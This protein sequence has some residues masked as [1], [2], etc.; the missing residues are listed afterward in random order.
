MN[1]GPNSKKHPY[2]LKIAL[3]AQCLIQG[4]LFYSVFADMA[5]GQY[6]RNVP[7]AERIIKDL[8]IDGCGWS[9]ETYIISWDCFESYLKE[10]QNPILYHTIYTIISHW[11]WYVSSLGKFINYAEKQN[12]PEKQTNKDLL[13]LSHRPFTKQIEIIKNETGILLNVDNDTLDLVEEMH[14]VRNLGMHNEWEIDDIYLKYTKTKN[15]KLGEKRIF[16]FAEM[17]KWHFAFVQLIG[18]LSSEIAIC[19]AQVPRYE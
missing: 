11:D 6:V 5:T 13:K 4:S 19:Y 18:K 15:Q 1:T 16:G 2:P 14:L 17:T 8:L 7:D 12:S 3:R 9:E 10:F